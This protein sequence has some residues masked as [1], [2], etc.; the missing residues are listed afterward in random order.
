MA[1]VSETH[2][3][4]E[5]EKRRDLAHLLVGVATVILALAFLLWVLW[6]IGASTKATG[7]DADGVRCYKSASEMACIKTAEPAR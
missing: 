6:Q 1:V 4:H 2:D 3:L 7:F 5:H